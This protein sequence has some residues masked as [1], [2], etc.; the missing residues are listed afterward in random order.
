MIRL[1]QWNV[2]LEGNIFL[3]DLNLDCV[4]LYLGDNIDSCC[5]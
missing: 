3:V 1:S 2:A 4:K 5:I